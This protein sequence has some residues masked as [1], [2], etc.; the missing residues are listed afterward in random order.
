MTVQRITVAALVPVTPGRAWDLFTDPNAITRWNFASDDWQCPSAQIDLTVGGTHKARM[1]AKDGSFGFDF[2]GT[3]SEVEAPHAL[4]LV[5]GDGRTSRTTFTPSSEG[6]LVE[7]I[8]EAEQQNPVEMQR[9][10]WQAILDNYR[11]HVE[12]EASA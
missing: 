2:E 1:E 8:F 12:Q 7:T 11:K 4:T 3:Y 9:A 5:M 10:G 6:T